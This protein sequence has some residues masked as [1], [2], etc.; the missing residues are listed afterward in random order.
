M[1]IKSR[2]VDKLSDLINIEDYPELQNQEEE[3]IFAVNPPPQDMCCYSCRKNVSELEPFGVR[4]IT[5]GVIQGDCVMP[6]LTID[7][8]LKKKFR[9][10][11]GYTFASWECRYCF[12]LSEENL[13]NFPPDEINLAI[14]GKSRSDE[15]T[16]MIQDSKDKNVYRAYHEV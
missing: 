13:D 10:I 1:L 11:D 2:F 9:Q 6:Y 8:K 15:W 7:N 3:I 5:L 4:V 16:L 12:F 14:K